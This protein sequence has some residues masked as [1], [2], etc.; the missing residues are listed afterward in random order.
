M[1]RILRPRPPVFR[2]QPQGPSVINSASPFSA[3]LR[4]LAHAQPGGNMTDLVSGI[5]ASIVGTAAP[6]QESTRLGIGVDTNIPATG[7][8]RGLVFPR[9][10][11]GISCAPTGESEWSIFVVVDVR[12]ATST[13]E[14]VVARDEG[15][16]TEGCW[17]LDY[18]PASQSFRPLL[19]TDSTQGW[20]IWN[21]VQANEQ[22]KSSNRGIIALC[23]SWRSPALS[24]PHYE[25]S[26]AGVPGSQPIT[27]VLADNPSNIG[28]A[29]PSANGVFIGGP[30]FTS[31]ASGSP[32]AIMQVAVWR[33][34]WSRAERERLV[35]DPLQLVRAQQ[36]GFV[37]L[38]VSLPIP[39]LSL[40]D[41]VSLGAYQV[42]PRV[43]LSF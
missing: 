17:A 14:F 7:S 29:A 39:V 36:A 41:A 11:V 24:N 15:S 30:E 6:T 40:P 2:I 13:N 18:F 16:A 1:A 20:T 9:D 34:S 26:Y 3:G 32:G 19:R 21:D 37:P 4:M 31:L 28:A 25:V 43:T 23:V 27:K 35:S 8:P 33:R 10:P 12:D 42:T 5:R 38:N 22:F